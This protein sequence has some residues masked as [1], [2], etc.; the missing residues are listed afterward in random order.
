[1]STSSSN[2]IAAVAASD[3]FDVMAAVGGWRGI[4]ESVVPTLLFLGLYIA[5]HDTMRAVIA[6]LA[7]CIIFLAARAIQRVPVA[8][9]CGGLCAMAI[10]AALV[11]KTGEASNVFF[12]GIILNAVY[13]IALLISL[14]VRWPLFGVLFS[15]ATGTRMQWR[16]EK[17]YKDVKKRH[18]IVTWLWVVVFALRL[19]IELP[20]YYAD[21]TEALGIAKLILGLPLFAL[22]AWFSWLIAP[23]GA[24]LDQLK[25]AQQSSEV[26]EIP[27]VPEI[28]Q[29]EEESS[30][31]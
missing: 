7:V 5:T 29:L 1:M 15:L 25:Q 22:A 8:P 18:Y 26:S 6:A 11:W 30:S 24:I 19:A 23:K 16:Q 13:G 2:N 17:E 14:L 12:W 28:S 4:I 27:E 10:S 9:A 20:L 31:S 3:D 21:A